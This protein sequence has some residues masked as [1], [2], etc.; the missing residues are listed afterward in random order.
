MARSFVRLFENLW[1]GHFQGTLWALKEQLTFLDSEAVGAVQGAQHHL[2]CAAELLQANRE[3]IR[4][5]LLSAVYSSGQEVQVAVV[6]ERAWPEGARIFSRRLVPALKEAVTRDPHVASTLRQHLFDPEEDQGSRVWLARSEDSDDFDVAS[7]RLCIAGQ[8]VYSGSWMARIVRAL[9]AGALGLMN[10][11]LAESISGYSSADG[12]L[13]ARLIIIRIFPDLEGAQVFTRHLVEARRQMLGNVLLECPQ[14]ASFGDLARVLKRLHN[15]LSVTEALQGVP[16]L[17]LALLSE[18]QDRIEAELRHSLV[19]LITEKFC[20]D[21]GA[22]EAALQLLSEVS[23][24]VD[25]AIFGPVKAHFLC[26]LRSEFLRPPLDFS[27]PRHA[28]FTERAGKFGVDFGQTTS[29]VRECVSGS[30]DLNLL[31]AIYLEGIQDESIN[32]AILAKILPHPTDAG[33]GSHRVRA[34]EEALKVASRLPA[35]PLLSAH[36]SHLLSELLTPSGGHPPPVLTELHVARLAT[37]LSPSHEQ[38]GAAPSEV[39]FT[40]PKE[41]SQMF[42]LLA[43]SN[44]QAILDP[45]AR[46]AR[47]RFVRLDRLRSILPLIQM[48]PASASPELKRTA[49]QKKRDAPSASTTRRG[50][51]AAVD[52]AELRRQRQKQQALD[53]LLVLISC[54]PAAPPHPDAPAEGQ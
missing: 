24:V 50:T 51:P 14:V 45:Q 11:W 16:V 10:D 17:R 33:D 19:P 1:E 37:L 21:S 36:F 29:L 44:P 32:R 39:P 3:L 7:Q 13:R 40:A 25:P 4:A 30:S 27:P 43:S 23:S 54:L 20:P 12:L 48:H 26:T 22:C 15:H 28:E 6:E 34:V 46:A 2:E 49:S 38:K 41:W 31:E 53:D 8:R 47:F 9:E 52:E 35:S 18:E 5:R 42:A